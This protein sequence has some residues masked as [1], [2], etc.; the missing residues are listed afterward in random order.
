M[1]QATVAFSDLGQDLSVL[2]RQQVGAG[3]AS[4]IA[5]N[6]MPIA[7][8]CPSARRTCACR[9]PSTFRIADCLAPAAVIRR[10]PRS[11]R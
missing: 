11:S 10:W 3:R 2:V 4:W 8:A 6:T 7:F 1:L 5:E 9:W